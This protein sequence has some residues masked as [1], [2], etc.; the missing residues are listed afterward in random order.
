MPRFLLSVAL[1]S[2]TASVAVA[3]PAPTVEQCLATPIP[4][5]EPPAEDAIDW[6]D[7][8]FADWCEE[9]AAVYCAANPNSAWC[10]CYW[11]GA[12]DL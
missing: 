1:L 5:D 9:R 7:A 6:G 8:D 4:F 3:A 11:S 10:A 12:F 2:L